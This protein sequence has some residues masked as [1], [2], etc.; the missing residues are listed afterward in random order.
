MSCRA[1]PYFLTDSKAR[2]LSQELTGIEERRPI[3]SRD[4]GQFVRDF[5][6]VVHRVTDQTFSPAIYRRLLGA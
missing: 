5:I 2:L 6:R 1:A 4:Y 3:N